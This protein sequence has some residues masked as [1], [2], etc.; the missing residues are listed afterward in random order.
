MRFGGAGGIRTSIKISRS[1]QYVE[2]RCFQAI[3]QVNYVSVSPLFLL[4]LNLI[5][6]KTVVNSFSSKSIYSLS[7]TLITWQEYITYG[8]SDIAH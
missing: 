3:D 4:N 2:N 8:G 5:V 1:A 6:V 7:A